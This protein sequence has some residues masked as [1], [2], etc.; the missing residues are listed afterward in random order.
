[1]Y[2]GSNGWMQ[3]ELARRYRQE[4]MKQAEAYRL[5][6]QARANEPPQSGKRD[7]AAGITLWLGNH[8]IDWGNALLA[9]NPKGQVREQGC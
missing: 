5:I 7:L 3:E 6:R 1:M 2:S 9:F 4:L 8:L